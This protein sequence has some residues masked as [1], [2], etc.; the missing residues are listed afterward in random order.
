MIK[1]KKIILRD[2]RE[3]FESVEGHTLRVVNYAYEFINKYED[4]IEKLSKIIDDPEWTVD[5][6][7]D[8]IFFSA[9]FH[10]IGKITKSFQNTI[11]NG[12]KSNHPFYALF[13]LWSIKDFTYRKKIRRYSAEINLLHFIIT[14]HHIIFKANLYNE[15]KYYFWESSNVLL[16]ATM[17]FFKEYKKIYKKYFY[18]DCEYIFECNIISNDEV[19]KGWERYSDLTALGFFENKENFEK[20]RWLY[21]FCSGI[22]NLSDWQASA[23]FVRENTDNKDI[24]KV[25]LEWEKLP[26]EN[27]LKKS[28]L[29]KVDKVFWKDYQVKASKERKNILMEIPTGE[30]KTEA[31]LLWA[32]NNLK[33]ENTKIIYTLP[34]QTTSN[35]LYERVIDIF[36]KENCGIIH[37]SSDIILEDQFTE[38]EKLDIE[39]YRNERLFQKTFNKPITVSTLDSFIKFF[40]NIGRWNIATKNFFN[41]VLIIDEVHS[42]DYKLL[43]FLARNLEILDKLEIK[44]CIMSASFPDKLKNI[45]L[46]NNWKEKFEYI[47]DKKLFLKKANAI[48]KRDVYLEE[49]VDKLKELYNQG[50]NILVVRNTIKHAIRI[51]EELRKDRNIRIM[52]YHSDFKKGDRKKKED[53]I[54]ERLKSYDNFILVATQVVE[55]SLDIDFDAMFT[56]VAPIDALI[57]RFGRV[58]RKKNKIKKGK[59]F[60][61]EKIEN[62]DK[63]GREAYPYKE[64]ILKQSLKVIENGYF[65][66]REYS[67]WINKVFENLYKKD[68]DFINKLDV[69]FKEGRDKYDNILKNCFGIAKFQD[70][71]DIR[72]IDKRLAKVDCYLKSDYEKTLNGERLKF[73]HLIPVPFYLLDKA[74]FIEKDI[75]NKIYN[76]VVNLDYNYDIGLILD[77]KKEEN[78]I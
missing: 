65:E 33:N 17:K 71:Y 30:G 8:L 20:I 16:P 48:E 26:N 44:I 51:F 73:D 9:Y 38:D 66:I 45:I 77:Y 43:G 14:T 23:D 72:D 50:K 54:V 29:K 61:Y 55:I 37:S 1:A 42:Y 22:I 57:Q 4:E 40:I 6:I 74:M 58:N 70:E 34:T 25:V 27:L 39:N 67:E 18:K 68:V 64:N 53:E 7:K 3:K 41:A 10:D 35:K 12:K 49:D 52:L 63:L 46:G 78:I 32:I 2:G 47:T 11:E 21:G 56:D 31:A 62:R 5:K 13:T 60:I 59:V 19:K 24:K 15:D 36:G 76:P 75:D 69:L 28:L